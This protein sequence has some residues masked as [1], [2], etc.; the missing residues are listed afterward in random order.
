MSSIVFVLLI[1]RGWCLL[2]SIGDWTFSVV[3]RL[4]LVILIVEGVVVFFFCFYNAG[5]SCFG[6]LLP[7][8]GY[9]LFDVIF[10][11]FSEWEMTY[12]YGD[13]E[14]SYSISF[15]LLY[16]LCA[17]RPDL[18]LLLSWIIISL[19]TVITALVSSRGVVLSF[20]GW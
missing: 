17:W 14:S 8:F 5:R 19:F 13:V 12:I 3:F 11:F 1:S 6:V 7:L 15:W 2:L 9:F 10:L 4:F 18:L 20:R 16:L